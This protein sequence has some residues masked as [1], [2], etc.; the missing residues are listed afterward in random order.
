MYAWFEQELK[1][2]TPK[3]RFPL[4][5]VVAARLGKA[6]EAFSNMDDAIAAQCNLLLDP[7]FDSLRD[8]PRFDDL[9]RRAGLSKIEI[10]AP[11]TTP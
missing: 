11:V 3:P 1:K 2:T 8:D 7:H 9:L 10:P 4:M 5:A 6:D